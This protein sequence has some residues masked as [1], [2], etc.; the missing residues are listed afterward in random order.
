MTDTDTFH[1]YLHSDNK[2]EGLDKLIDGLLGT[3]PDPVLE[4]EIRG[5]AYDMV[6]TYELDRETGE[7]ALLGVKDGKREL[8]DHHT[9]EDVTW[10][11]DFEQGR[12]R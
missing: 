12:L 2:G 1:V 9:D 6:C 5:L 8:G 11:H 7:V 3:D 10:N 4:R